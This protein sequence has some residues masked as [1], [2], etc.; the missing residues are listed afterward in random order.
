MPVL[1]PKFQNRSKIGIG[2]QLV[3]FPRIK[4]YNKTRMF[5]PVLLSYRPC[6]SG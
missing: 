6:L 3:A 2:V 5:H 1:T 4:T